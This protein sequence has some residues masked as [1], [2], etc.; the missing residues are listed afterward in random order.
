MAAQP[1]LLARPRCRPSAGEK[2]NYKEE[3]KTAAAEIFIR[4]LFFSPSI[5]QSWAAAAAEPSSYL[6]LVVPFY[7]ACIAFHSG[8]E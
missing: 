7:D 6:F 2:L 8:D 5:L 1:P 4:L 3:E